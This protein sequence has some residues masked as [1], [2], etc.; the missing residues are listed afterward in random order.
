MAYRKYR[1]QPVII[2]GIRFASKAEGAYYR[3]VRNSPKKITL[4]EHFEIVP[5]FKLNGKRYSARKYTPDFCMYDGD[6][7]VKVVDVKGGNATM[8]TDAKLRMLLFMI[9]YKIPITSARYD[10]RTGLFTEEQL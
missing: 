8:T 5:A 3:L 6:Q 10:Y 9:R 2:D 7:L 1:A 4:Q